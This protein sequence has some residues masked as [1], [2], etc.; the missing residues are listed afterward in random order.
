MGAEQRTLRAVGTDHRTSAASRE[1]EAPD[2]SVAIIGAG[3]AGLGM[4]IKL[5]DA[6]RH[7]FQIF[8][9]AS[10]LG[11]TWR[12]NTYPGC[13]CD[14]P[15]HLYSYS[16]EQ[17]PDWTRTFGPWWE[18]LE[19]L[20]HCADKYAVRP[21]IRFDS[22]VTAAAWDDD[23]R[24][25]RI[26][27]N[28]SE[29]ITARILVAGTGPFQRPRYPDVPGLDSFEGPVMHSARWD[30]DV[31]LRGKDVAAIGTGASAIQFVPEVAKEA[32]ALHIFQRTPPW[33]LAKQ[34]MPVSDAWRERFIRSPRLTSAVRNGI[35]LAAESMG[36]GFVVDPRL[37]RVREALAKR[38]IRKSI[39]DPAL[40]EKVTPHYTMGCKR[41]LYSNDYYPALCRDNVHLET[42]PIERITHDSVVTR[43]GTSRKVDAIVLG[44]GFVVDE[45]LTH[46]SV[47]GRDGLALNDAWQKGAEAYYGITVADFPNLFL[48]VGPNTGLGHNSIVFMIEAQVHY[49][50]KCLDRMDRD[51]FTSLEVRA[52]EQRLFNERLMDRMG[53]M[54]WSSGCQSWYLDQEG[55]N[56]TIWP[57]FT[58]EYWLRTRRPDPRAFRGR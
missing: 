3:F 7:D 14:I 12:D 25:W 27:I 53:R 41:I 54:V 51:G 49:I 13:A 52:S 35:Y 34:D 16:F 11:G 32:Q 55:R 1:P 15:S 8:E 21:H 38:F 28:D 2:L 39:A 29:E 50:M 24:L 40:R 17:K 20:E 19:Y 33:V 56:F 5:K 30:H 22:P 6:E 23:A 10:G 42:D 18:I 46:V 48:L 57:G 36:A 43:S 47:R 4:A 37:M 31:D 44:T 26:T 58:T 9:A 45:F